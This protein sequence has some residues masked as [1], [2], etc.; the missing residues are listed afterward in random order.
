[1]HVCVCLCFDK[2]VLAEKRD[3]ITISED[4]DWALLRAT[5]SFVSSSKYMHSGT[6]S[7]RKRVYIKRHKSPDRK[8]KGEGRRRDVHQKSCWCKMENTP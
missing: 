6:L 2:P 5:L 4:S 1:M 3:L 8:R 7:K